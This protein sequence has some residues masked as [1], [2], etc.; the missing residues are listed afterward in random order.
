MGESIKGI[1]RNY[2]SIVRCEFLEDDKF[3][4]RLVEYYKFKT[5]V[6]PSDDSSKMWI[7]NFDC[8]MR[9]YIEDY[10]FSKKLKNSVDIESI[11]KSD[12][13]NYDKLVDYMLKFSEKYD[14]DKGDI[15]TNTKWI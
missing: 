7:R 10:T 3:S 15:I 2:N 4:L 11:L 6:M 14:N 9:K 1:C 12:F 8:I 5:D 13:S